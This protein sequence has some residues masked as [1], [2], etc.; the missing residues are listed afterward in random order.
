M[1][2]K[3]LNK[4]AQKT[5]LQQIH[6]S[7]PSSSCSCS[8]SS[9]SS[10]SKAIEHPT[11]YLDSLEIQHIIIQ[12]IEKT[13]RNCY[14]RSHFA[15][16]I[17]LCHCMLCLGLTSFS[18]FLLLFCLQLCV[19]AE[20]VSSIHSTWNLPFFSIWNGFYMHLWK[21]CSPLFYFRIV[22]HI[23]ILEFQ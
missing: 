9:S 8:S 20:S 10:S 3:I 7:S 12:E 13:D 6:R 11:K 17:V 14:L 4:K 19:V 22:I 21:I 15:G 16:I 2:G 5:A 18:T 1:M 23:K